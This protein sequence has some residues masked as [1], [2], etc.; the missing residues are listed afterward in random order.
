MYL[1]LPRRFYALSRANNSH[2]GLD[3]LL[4]N[5]SVAD[6]VRLDA[7]NGL[8]DVLHAE[9]LNLGL[10]AFVSNDSKELI[11]FCFRSHMCHAKVSPI[12]SVGES[13]KSGEGTVGKTDGVEVRID[14][15]D[16]QAGRTVIQEGEGRQ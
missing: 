10:D 16:G 12:G 5:G 1:F 8:S 2:L 6:L 3:V 14:I 7:V 11:H 9:L 15:Q 13:W 4:E